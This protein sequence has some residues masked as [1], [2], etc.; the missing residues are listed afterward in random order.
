MANSG[1]GVFWENLRSMPRH[2]RDAVIRHGAPT[3]DRARSQAVFTNFLLHIHPTRTH[4]RTLRLS[5]TW[6]LGVSLIS[7]F[8]ILTVTGVLLMVY[9]APSIAH[10]YDSIKDL[11][12]VVPTGRFV[13]NIHRWTAHLM[14]FTVILHMAR[15]F[16]TSAYKAPREFNWLLGMGLFVLTLG[17]SFSGYLLPWDQLAYWAV[18]IGANIAASPNELVHALGLPASFNIGD[19]QKELLLGANSVGQEALTRFY[20]L[21]VMVLPI[22]MT[23]LIALHVWRI[24]KDGG[25]ARPEGTPTPAGKGV[26]TMQAGSVEPA[27]APR[28]TY[29]LMCIIKGRSPYTGQDPDETV[30]SWPYLLR[31]EL[32]VFMLT[33]LVCVALGL[34]FDAPL[35][36]IAN[37]AVPENPAK[38][39]WYFLGLQEMVSY[40]A[41]VGGM[42]VPAIV[43]LG[44]ALIPFLDREE[45]PAGVWFSGKAGRRVMT[46][47]V[48]FAGVT[49]VLAVAVPVRYGWLRNWFPDIN[50]LWIILFNPG[51]LLTAAYA[52]WSLFVLSRTRSTRLGAVALFTCFLVGFVIL[53]Y[54]GTYL[55][56]PNWDF[57][58]SH[59]SWPVH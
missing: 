33:M 31:G 39:P 35:K 54:V 16:Y 43:V 25:L 53:T 19:L 21:H 6:G 36:E 4:P 20:L 22:L 30:P 49:A 10:A 24:R 34:L 28:K 7:Q 29:G 32:L 37:A 40:S 51:S 3:S 14:V 2:L 47:S 44:L 56:G 18:T 45:E 23:L 15:V 13:R 59:A 11:H 9:Y 1:L 8:I 38:A 58:W 26:G 50:Q 42:V 46:W 55:R 27:A 17:L 41:F 12:Y 57:Y 48:L 52:V 5:T